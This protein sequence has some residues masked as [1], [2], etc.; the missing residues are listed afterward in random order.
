MI[1]EIQQSD[2]IQYVLGF[3]QDETAQNILL[4]KKK[5]PSFLA[6]TYN[7]LG[8]KI[9]YLESPINA[10]VRECLEE[11]NLFIPHNDWLQIGLMGDGITYEIFVF[12]SVTSFS[13][14]KNKTDEPLFKMSW[15][16]L[17]NL[18][19]KNLLSPNVY[20]ILSPI[21]QT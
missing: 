9:E 12:F 19:S 1:N 5:R 6:G 3:L 10:M 8:G 2:K 14:M 4:I 16:E 7:G 15:N 21:S 13:G 17:D 11:S 18:N 20:E